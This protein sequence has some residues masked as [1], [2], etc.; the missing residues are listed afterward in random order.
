MQALS[1]SEALEVSE[2]VS[3]F[4]EVRDSTVLAV[5]MSDASDVTEETDSTEMWDVNAG[6]SGRFGSTGATA[7]GGL[8]LVGGVV[9]FDKKLRYAAGGEIGVFSTSSRLSRQGDI[10]VAGL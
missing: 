9:I 10:T 8:M 3:V 5:L 6:R 4:S 7:E 1:L 2:V